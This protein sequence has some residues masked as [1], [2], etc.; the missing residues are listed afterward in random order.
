LLLEFLEGRFLPSTAPLSL[1]GQLPLAFEA[2]RGQADPGVDFL[3]RGNGY[4]LAL[5]PDQA[6]LDLRQGSSADALRVRLVGANPSFQVV[7]R[8]ELI[9]RSNY[10]VGN[11]PGRWHTDIPNFGRVEYDRVYPGVNLVY[12]GNQGQLEYDFI[13]APGANPNVITLSVQGA[14]G[15]ALDAQGNL[16]LHTMGGDVVEHAPVLYQDSGGARQAVSGNFV[17]ENN[18]Q[19]G[20]QVGAYDPSRPLVIDPTLVYSTYLGGPS[21]GSFAVGAIAVDNSGN[22]YLTG[23]DGNV[24]VAKLNAA[25]TALLYH[26]VLGPY[27]VGDQNANGYGIAV[28]SA[29]DA[30]VTGLGSVPTTANALA[31]TG[32][33]DPNNS[34]FVS[35]LNAAGSGLI[36][37]TYLPGGNEAG[38]LAGGASGSIAVDSSGNAYVTG[39]AGPGLPTTAGAFQTAFAGSGINHA[40]NAFLAKID[41]YLSGAA[42]LLYC[43]YLGGSGTGGSVGDAGTGVAVDSAGN[44]YLTGQTYSANFPTTA[45]AFQTKYGGNGDVFVAKINPSLSGSASLVYS[46]YLGGSGTDGLYPLYNFDFRN[47]TPTGPG[48]AVDGAGDAYV[49]GFTSSTNFPTTPGAYETSIGSGNGVAF[50]AKLNPTGSQLVY[51]TY[52]GTNSTKSGVRTEATSIAVDSAGNAFVAGLTYSTAFPT[53][54]PIQHSLGGKTGS[55]NAFITTL[56]ATGSGLLFSTFLGGSRSHAGSG[57]PTADFALGLALDAAGN[58]YVAGVTSSVNFPTTAGAYQTTYSGGDCDGFVTKISPVAGPA[59]S[60]AGGSPGGLAGAVA[61]ASRTA[62]GALEGIDLSL[63]LLTAP[64]E[65]IPRAALRCAGAGPSEARPPVLPWAPLLP[66]VREAEAHSPEPEPAWLDSIFQSAAHPWFGE[67]LAD[68]LAL[69]TLG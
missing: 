6:V 24:F 32:G 25:G 16:V 41:P 38:P 15:M 21:I 9:T 49:A 65:G 20:F 44:A 2:N 68:D 69:A 46:T 50:V 59:A 18:G 31:T 3:A 48:I 12:Y 61:P 35:V 4:T 45:G 29:G 43:T 27:S 52:L 11:D 54:N 10:L 1:Y 40:T 7:G 28:D 42:S 26:T 57:F 47:L 22:T 64:P 14:Q 56:N 39:P 33:T 62:L 23:N 8:D 53:V 13:V 51:S 67:A 60:P 5:S 34:T 63:P 19:V 36:Y 58:T 55:A 66:V 17:L 37:S 30:Y